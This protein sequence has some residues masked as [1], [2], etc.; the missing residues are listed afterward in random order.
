MKQ[1]KTQLQNGAT[2]FG[3]ARRFAR[4]ACIGA[5][6]SVATVPAFAAVVDTAAI[7]AQIAEGQTDASTIAGY[8]A[9]ALAVLACVGVVFSM[10]RKA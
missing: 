7:Q 6:V 8:I 4:N 2:A 10:L 1:L 9:L 3:R 5:V